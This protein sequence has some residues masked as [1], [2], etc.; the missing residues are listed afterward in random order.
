MNTSEPN[1]RGAAGVP[2]ATPAGEPQAGAARGAERALAPR[3]EPRAHPP[4]IGSYVFAAALTAAFLAAGITGVVRHEMWR[5]E[6]QAW[7]IVHDSAS[8]GALFLNVRLETHPALWHLTAWLLA[9]ATESL[10]AFQLLNLAF[11]AAG[12]FLIAR[13][14]PFR[15]LE[16]ALLAFGYFSL[17]EYGMVA[18]NYAIGA[19]LVYA[20]CAAFPNRRYWTLGA[21]LF[22]ATQSS[23]HALIIACGL[24]AFLGIDAAAR[25]RRDG[26][27]LPAGAKGALALTALGVALTT[28]QM[29]ASYGPQHTV[30]RGSL[31]FEHLLNVVGS[32][33]RSYV[34]VP[35]ISSRPYWGSNALAGL[36]D[37]LGLGGDPGRLVIAAL[38]V[39]LVAFAARTL[40][41]SP[42][43]LLFYAVTSVA[44]L[45]F[46]FAMFQ[47]AIR[48]QGHLFVALVAALWLA[49]AAGRGGAASAAP[50]A[51]APEPE[52][53][54]RAP[55]WW[56][57]LL[58]AQAIGGLWAWQ[59]D[60][61]LP[62]SRASAAAGFIRQER[63]DALPL[64]GDRA[65]PA[66]SLQPYLEKPIV[67]LADGRR[68]SFIVW[69]PAIAP[70][71]PD[72]E[73]MWSNLLRETIDR[74]TG[75]VVLILNYAV[76]S[77][78]A[79]YESREIGRFTGS[80]VGDEDYFLYLVEWPVRRPLGTGR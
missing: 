41:R 19:T 36:L 15:K 21:I 52:P 17:F 27:A 62:F 51:L 64:F 11:A 29:R 70:K 10:R 67:Y 57:A 31:G 2:N 79:R 30:A 54:T 78:P 16:K 13:F 5:D 4:R 23:L 43:A 40:Q 75:H 44:L 50:G 25:A 53:G 22:L 33:W 38:S 3:E 8:L 73:R 47:G 14:A 18:R 34:P 59:A 39:A 63:L 9:R 68:G 37:K 61:R 20:F 1:E 45:L 42:R 48:H 26:R 77:A 56:T 46:G 7:M 80:L 71:K 32:V 74:P 12:V 58:L 28:F 72:P 35:E 49:P 69:G 60:V 6:V 76:D 55:C 24:A 66:S 65:P